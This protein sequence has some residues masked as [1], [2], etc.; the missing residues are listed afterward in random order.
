MQ[1]KAEKNSG[2][3]IFIHIC[4]DRDGKAT[5]V[6]EYHENKPYHIQWFQPINGESD[7]WNGDPVPWNKLVIISIIIVV[8]YSIYI[9]LY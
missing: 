6:Y 3:G 2:K 8:L 4:I 9:N 5:E 1:F 7:D